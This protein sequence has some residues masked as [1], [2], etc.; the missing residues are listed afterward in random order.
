MI[1]ADYLFLLTDVDG[2]YTSN[3]DREPAGTQT[4]VSTRPRHTLFRPSLTPL[5]DLKSWSKHALFPS[6]S[7]IID[8]GAHRVL[9]RRDSG[10]RLLP[11]GVVGVVGAFASGQ[12]VRI[13]VRRHSDGGSSGDT[14][15]VSRLIFNS[16]PPVTASPVLASS[17]SSSGA[18]LVPQSR[19]LPKLRLMLPALS[20]MTKSIRIIGQDRRAGSTLL[21]RLAEVGGQEAFGA[22]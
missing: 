3:P 12:A 22:C 19:S 7:V 10:R 15:P 1:H 17:L 13:V 11:A 6:G 16:Q 21:S 2:L 4:P 9:S 18:S 20:S 5:R 14:D 8:A